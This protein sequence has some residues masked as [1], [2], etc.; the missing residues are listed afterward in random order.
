MIKWII[1]NLNFFSINICV[2]VGYK[3]EEIKQY[4]GND[5]IYVFQNQQKGTAHAVQKAESVISN[6]KDILILPADS[7]MVSKH[8]IDKLSVVVGQSTK[9]VLPGIE[10]NMS[11]FSQ[12]L[13]QTMIQATEKMSQ[14]F[15]KKS[16]EADEAGKWQVRSVIELQALNTSIKKLIKESD[17]QTQKNSD[18]N[19]RLIY[20]LKNL[21]DKDSA[22][23]HPREK[24]KV[25]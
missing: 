23:G 9:E 12:D 19:K 17:E 13:G 6:Y 14:S 5:L 21:L 24:L 3:S 20:T 7:P 16:T 1:D 22:L 2:I 18:H 15:D 4:L 11:Q 8:S 25:I 10:Q